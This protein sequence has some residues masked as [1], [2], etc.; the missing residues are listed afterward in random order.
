MMN[1]LLVSRHLSIL[2]PLTCDALLRFGKVFWD[3]FEDTLRVHVR[4]GDLADPTIKFPSTTLLMVLESFWGLVQ[5]CHERIRVMT[6]EGLRL[7]ASGDGEAK[8]RLVEAFNAE[9]RVLRVLLRTLLRCMINVAW[10]GSGILYGKSSERGTHHPAVFDVQR[11]AVE[12]LSLFL[13]PLCLLCQLSTLFPVTDIRHLVYHHENAQKLTQLDE[14]E[15]FLCHYCFQ[16]SNINSSF[17]A[18]NGMAQFRSCWLMLSYYRLTR[19]AL[20]RTEKDATSTASENC[21]AR[22]RFK[23][24]GLDQMYTIACR[25]H[26][27]PYAYAILRLSANHGRHRCFETS[28][29]QQW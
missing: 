23:F 5:R 22:K 18:E 3:T 21:A 17:Y 24:N 28:L 15:S 26:A 16:P 6:R 11:I 1:R 13:R 9:S 2:K 8:A 29:I 12:V 27:A 4:S 20:L 19:E 25:V 7:V 14:G 10:P